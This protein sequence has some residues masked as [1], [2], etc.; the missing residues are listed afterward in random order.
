MRTLI[1]ASAFVLAVGAVMSMST[2]YAKTELRLGYEPPRTDSQHLAAKEF[3]K[4]VEDGTK[5]EVVIKLFPDSTLGNASSLINGIRNGSVD[6]TVLG[7]NNFA[8]LAPELKVLDLPF[9]YNTKED[10]YK[11]L[12]GEVGQELLDG[13]AKYN[14]KGLAF[15]E[16]G[17]RAISNNK[18]PV[19]TPEDVKGLKMRVPGAP[20]QVKLFEVLGTNPVPMP[21]GEL[22]TALETNTV[23]GQDHPLGVFYSAKLY[24]VQKY[25]S[26]TNHQYGSLLL[27]MNLD[28]F[29]SLTPDQQKVLVDAAR[30]AANVQRKINADKQAE[31]IE[32]FRKSGVEVIETIDPKPFKDATFDKVSQLYKDEFGDSMIKKIE[33]A[34]AK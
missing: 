19:R 26:L 30:K 14:I 28:K 29:N 7:S 13:M 4:M 21:L 1:K 27:A 10:A 17:Y 22:Y 5:G 25:L 3:K 15:W 31:L 2:V 12:D 16:N 11:V 8:G 23:D 6:M 33:A 24:E 18:R 9:F 32:L 34:M 20:M